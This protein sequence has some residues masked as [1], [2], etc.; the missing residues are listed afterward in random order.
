MEVKHILRLYYFLYFV[1]PRPGHISWTLY[2]L[3]F[4]TVRDLNVVKYIVIFYACQR[5]HCRTVLCKYFQSQGFQFGTIL[6]LLYFQTARDFNVVQDYVIISACQGILFGTLLY[7]IFR[8]S[9][10]SVWY[11]SLLY[12]QTARD[13]SVVQ[14]FIIFSECQGFQCSTGLCLWS[15]SVRCNERVECID[16]SDEVSCGRY[17]FKFHIK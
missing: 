15:W 6:T 8:L 3:Y 14:Y 4:Q 13:F 11:S 10:I 17:I 12:F 1:V 2:L 9:G 7:Y 5:F 16:L